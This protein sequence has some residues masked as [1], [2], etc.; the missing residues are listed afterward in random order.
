MILLCQ[1]NVGKR[2][3]KKRKN[4][5]GIGINMYVHLKIVHNINSDL[6][7]GF[8]MSC[9]AE[10]RAKKQE[11]RNQKTREEIKE[12]YKIGKKYYKE[13]EKTHE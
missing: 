12:S 7:G 11:K 9:N 6:V 1:Q 13:I 8:K 2:E 3:F 10:N 5:S 4:N